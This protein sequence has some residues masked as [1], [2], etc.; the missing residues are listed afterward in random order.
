MKRILCISISL[1]VLM[2]SGAGAQTLGFWEF[3]TPGSVLLDSSGNGMDG[4]V[5]FAVS[6]ETDP[7]PVSD[8]PSG[9]AGDLALDIVGGPVVADDS[10]ET[11]LDLAGQNF[12]AEL[13]LKIDEDLNGL[14]WLGTIYYGRHGTGWGIGFQNDSVKFTLFGVVDMFPQIHL[15]P[16][17]N[18]H[19]L[20]FLYEAGAGVT[21]YL[22]GEEFT[23]MAETRA[24][25]QTNTNILWLGTEDGASRPLPGKIDRFRVTSGLLD[26]S[27]LDSDAANPKPVTA[28]TIVYFPFDEESGPEYTDTAGGLIAYA[29][30]VWFA[31][32]QAPDYIEDTPSGSGYALEF[33]QGDHAIV[34]DPNET[35]NFQDQSFTTE[36]WAKP[37]AFAEDS[38][39][40]FRYGGSQTAPTD[41]GGYGIT[42]NR[43][44]GAVSMTFYQIDNGTDVSVTTPDGAF[45]VDGEWHHIAAVY[46]EDNFLVQIYIDGALAYEEE[47]ALGILTAKDTYLIHIGGEWDGRSAYIGS[48]DR[49]RISSGA[50]TADQLDYEEPVVA[51]VDWELF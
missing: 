32:M 15:S 33:A 11:L 12:T 31:L 17:G 8:S 34:N 43:A 35:L 39:I 16:D 40:L 3:D 46:D 30:T 22:D 2:A 5:G 14:S 36:I 44:T 23:Y 18:W 51:I 21:F 37:G 42:L 6:T 1:I 20:G 38:A 19:H 49:L 13:W 47:Y 48:L 50:L 41:S 10:A 28:D 4:K 9:A 29:G 7:V 24:M 26:P 25:I 45:P 27:Q